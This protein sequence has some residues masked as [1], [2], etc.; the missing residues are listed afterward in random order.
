MNT[1]LRPLWHGRVC[2]F[3]EWTSHSTRGL[4]REHARP[5]RALILTASQQKQITNPPDTTLTHTRERTHTHTG[6]TSDHGMT[7]EG[8]SPMAICLAQKHTTPITHCYACEHK[9][10]I[11][12]YSFECVMAKKASFYSL[13]V[14]LWPSLPYKSTLIHRQLFT[15]SSLLQLFCFHFHSRAPI[16]TQWILCMI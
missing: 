16:C 12:I 1:S 4:L 9:H 5:S 15:P 8:L 6:N 2:C 14:I 11:R 13:L 3:W 7:A 10:T